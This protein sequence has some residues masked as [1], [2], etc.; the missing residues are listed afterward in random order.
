MERKTVVV[1]RWKKGGV[2]ETY[3][4][5]VAFCAHH[6]EYPRHL[7]YNRWCG[8]VYQDDVLELRR[9]M[10]FQ[11]PLKTRRGNLPRYKQGRPRKG[12]RGKLIRPWRK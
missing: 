1:V 5:L 9:S 12:Q 4:S 10:F 2:V 3:S 11:H 8:G 6:P 7:I